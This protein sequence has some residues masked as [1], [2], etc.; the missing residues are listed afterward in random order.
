MPI[1]SVVEDR[2]IMSVKYRLL[3]PV[4]HFWPKLTQPAAWSLCD[5]GYED[6]NKD[7]IL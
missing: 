1:M 5:K 2:P 4:F 6:I 7:S 3:V